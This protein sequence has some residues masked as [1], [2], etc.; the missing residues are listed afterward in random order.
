[1]P[2]IRA[3]VTPQLALSLAL[4]LAA[5]CGQSTPPPV[6]APAVAEAP[7]LTPENAPGADASGSPVAPAVA[8]YELDV[9]KAVVP[10]A[11]ATGRLDGS[12]FTPTEVTLTGTELTFAVPKPGGAPGVARCLT[13]KFPPAGVKL[14]DGFRLVVKAEE[15]VSA[16]LPGVEWF[17]FAGDKP[18][19][20]AHEN[21]YALTLELGKRAAGK[22]SGTI[23]VS[24]PDGAKSYLAGTF[25]AEAR[26][27]AGDAPGADESPAVHGGVTVAGAPAGDLEVGVIGQ[28]AGQ[29][30][31]ESV[32]LPVA[33][34]PGRFTRT[35]SPRPT[36]LA[37]SAAGQFRYE[38][39]KLPA[40]RYLVWARQTPGPLAWKW[41]AVAA[42]AV[43]DTPLT[44][45]A[46]QAGAVAFT[47]T[48]PGGRLR[49]LPRDGDGPSPIPDAALGFAL[50]LD[51][52]FD[53]KTFAAVP[54]G[55]Y[56]VV[57]TLP[58]GEPWDRQPVEVKPGE[59]VTVKLK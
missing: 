37:L 55:R 12:P 31:T 45:D 59:T 43:T 35:E 54:P 30:V 41:V 19:G 23:A 52:A 32:S 48:Q 7:V 49:L 21:G 26:R 29:V 16:A 13:V 18:S 34:A 58:A 24:L 40:G 56:E 36:A 6:A 3:G 53:A 33:G 10:A 39:T 9:A 15:P 25:T 28:P 38:H 57:A 11:A 4:G 14:G 8:G 17:D 42:G 2:P 51:A 46:K 27:A 5:W 47:T 44:L 20:Q 22:Q 50:K 1:M